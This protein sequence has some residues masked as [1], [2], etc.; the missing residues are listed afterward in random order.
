V[1]QRACVLGEIQAGEVVLSHFGNVVDCWWGNISGEFPMV[2]HDA[3]VIMPN[4]LHFLIFVD[5]KSSNLNKSI[6][7][8][9]RFLA[10]E[11]IRRLNK[12][13][14]EELLQQLAEGVSH[15]EAIKGKLHRVFQPS[16]DSKPCYSEDFLQ[17]KLD[18]IHRNPVS[19]KWNLADDFMDYPHSSALFYEKEEQRFHPVTHFENVDCG[20]E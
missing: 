4:H 5:E 10:Y 12:S 13:G 19:G 1:Q 8:G 14:H 18:Y 16:F 7:N 9:K 11:I 6:A 15:K 2:Q 20:W 3:Y 17:Q